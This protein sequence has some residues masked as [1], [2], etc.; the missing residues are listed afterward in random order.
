MSTCI[1]I[2][3]LFG[4]KFTIKVNWLVGQHGLVPDVVV[5]VCFHFILRI[6]IYLHVCECIYSGW[7]EVYWLLVYRVVSHVYHL[8]WYW[9]DKWEDWYRSWLRVKWCISGIW[10]E[11]SMVKYTCTLLYNC[12]TSFRFLIDKLRNMLIS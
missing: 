3:S 8:V 5:F 11:I 9:A 12:I 7:I 4:I 6:V 1:K 2:I 10:L